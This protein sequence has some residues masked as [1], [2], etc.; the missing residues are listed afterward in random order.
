MEKDTQIQRHIRLLNGQLDP[1]SID[2]WISYKLRHELPFAPTTH[3][4]HYLTSVSSSLPKRQVGP[5]FT[6]QLIP[7]LFSH[8]CVLTPHLFLFFLLLLPFI[9]SQLSSGAMWSFLAFAS[10]NQPKYPCHSTLNTLLSILPARKITQQIIKCPTLCYFLFLPLLCQR[11]S[12]NSTV[13]KSLELL[14][15]LTLS[16]SVA[17]ANKVSKANELISHLQYNWIIKVERRIE[18]LHLQWTNSDLNFSL[19]LLW[20]LTHLNIQFFTG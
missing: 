9:F 13:T 7:S 15:T 19:H 17:I 16:A 8:H 4:T 2:H 6:C 18:P 11:Q 1:E 14:M 5:V 20:T 3:P 10:L 12:Y